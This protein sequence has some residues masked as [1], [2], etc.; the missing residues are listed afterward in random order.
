M[1]L[2]TFGG[3]ASGFSACEP[4][5]REFWWFPHYQDLEGSTIPKLWLAVLILPLFSSIRAIAAEKSSGRVA[6]LVSGHDTSLIEIVSSCL[7]RQLKSFNNVSVVDSEPGYYLRVMAIENRSAGKSLGYTLSVVVTRTVQDDY[8]RSSVPDE[9]RLAFLL[10]LYGKVERI[11]DSWIVS[12]A[13]D[14]LDQACRR[15]VET[16]YWGT[17]E[18]GR[19]PRRRLGEVI[20]GLVTPE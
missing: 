6:V 11:V 19:N 5:A 13:H 10:T 20:Y 9:A 4:F 8:L 2:D 17:L 15:I 12:A 1:G 7:T 14:D 18:Q 16:F 3:L